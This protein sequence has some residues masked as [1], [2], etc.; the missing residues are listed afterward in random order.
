MPEC[1]NQP[2]KTKQG[3]ELNIGGAAESGQEILD[4]KIE[5]IERE[6]K[7]S[8]D[9]AHDAGE[10]EDENAAEEHIDGDLPTVHTEIILYVR[11]S[12]LTA[13]SRTANHE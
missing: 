10:D 9:K 8:D 12:G 7:R 2:T 6:P 3:E 4:A 5:R 1:R 11:E 13:A